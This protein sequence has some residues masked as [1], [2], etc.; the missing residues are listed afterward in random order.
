[1]EMVARRLARPDQSPTAAATTAE[2]SAN[3]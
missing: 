1:V 2:V 3:A